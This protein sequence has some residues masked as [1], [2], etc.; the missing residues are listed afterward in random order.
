MFPITHEVVSQYFRQ[1]TFESS[2]LERNKIKTLGSRELS[3]K[4][5]AK[6]KK[7]AGSKG[8]SMNAKKKNNKSWPSIFTYITV[9]NI[10]IISKK[11][12]KE[13]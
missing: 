1:H 5:C 4:G 12:E 2:N 6:K 9:A 10:A 7:G 11:K 13:R 8:P 3:L